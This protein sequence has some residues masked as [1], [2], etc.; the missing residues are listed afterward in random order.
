MGIWISSIDYR[1]FN[2]ICNPL[3]HWSDRYFPPVISQQVSNLNCLQWSTEHKKSFKIYW[4]KGSIQHKNVCIYIL[5]EFYI[6]IVFIMFMMYTFCTSEFMYTKCLQNVCIQN[7]SHI[8]TN[9]CLQ[10]VCK[11]YPIFRQTFIYILHAKFSW[12]SSFDFVYKIYT[13]V[14]LNVIYT[15]YTFCIHQLYTSCTIFVCKMYTQFPC[16]Q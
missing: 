10:N 1:Q 8:L 5:Y 4:N 16:G 3:L 6:Q 11:V 2:A 7:V 15:S 12:R 9:F 13:K 14:C